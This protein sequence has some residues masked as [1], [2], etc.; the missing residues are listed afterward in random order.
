[1]VKARTMA[2]P[3]TA[4]QSRRRDEDF[5]PRLFITLFVVLVD[6]VMLYPI[7]N[8]ISI[9][10][11]SYT[12]YLENPVMLLPTDFS[13]AAYNQVFQYSL[14][15]TGYGVTLFVTIC[16]TVLGVLLTILT[17]YPLSRKQ[18]R[19]KGLFMGLILF[20]MFFSGGMIPSFLLVKSIGLLDTIWSLILPGCL[21]AY[22]VILVRN[23]FSSLPDSLIEAAEIDGAN[24]PF[25]LFRIV[26][27]LSKPIISTILLF[28][29]VG[30]WNSYFSAILYIRSRELWPLQL[31]LREIIMSATA[32]N[33]S[34]GGNLAE[35]G[36]AAVQPIMLQYASIVVAMVPILCIYPCLQKYFEKGIMMG[37]VKG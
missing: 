25:I 32:M 12:G 27:P 8:V 19:G 6:A 20:T 7:I 13:L 14:M 1:M 18:F 24:E 34:T 31:V 22:N 4:V 15:L 33:Q 26:V 17:A 29:A 35:M 2:R 16:G 9:S 30:Y 28:V 36:N 23:F 11:S 5:V 10:L 3:H 21:S 37:A